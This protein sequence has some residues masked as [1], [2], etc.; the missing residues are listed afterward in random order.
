MS[1]PRLLEAADIRA[2][3]RRWFAPP[4]SAI[5][6]E[7]A[8]STGARAHRHLDAVAMELWPSRGLAI[9][10]IEIKVNLYDW[11]REKNASRESG[12]GRPLL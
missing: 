10:G 11:R 8:Q 3:M 5:V 7:V 9:H 1:D 6:Y 4:E 2:A 12:G